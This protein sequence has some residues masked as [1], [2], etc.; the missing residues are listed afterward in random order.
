MICFGESVL[1]LLCLA[2][3][4][5]FYHHVILLLAG[6]IFGSASIIVATLPLRILLDKVPLYNS[7]LIPRKEHL[8][9]TVL[10]TLTFIFGG[11]GWILNVLMLVVK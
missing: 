1:G 5:L 3:G 6:M 7:A 4:M 8:V 10:T 11:V 9:V 2:V